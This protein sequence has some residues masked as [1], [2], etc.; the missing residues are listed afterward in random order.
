MIPIG[1]RVLS[2]HRLLRMTWQR[3]HTVGITK[4]TTEYFVGAFWY[5]CFSKYLALFLQWNV[6]SLPLKHFVFLLIAISSTVDVLM[7]FPPMQEKDPLR[8]PSGFFLLIDHLHRAS[9]DLVPSSFVF[10]RVVDQ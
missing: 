2:K 6:E 9:I 5:K 3:Q 4:S 8:L 7:R 10:C 1:C